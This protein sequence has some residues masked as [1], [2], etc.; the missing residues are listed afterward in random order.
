MARLGQLAS[1][2][3][4]AWVVQ[5]AWATLQREDDMIDFS[6]PSSSVFRVPGLRAQHVSHPDDM[7]SSMVASSLDY[8]KC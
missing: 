3:R 2:G 7:P 8:I 6:L 5:N 4:K 1:L